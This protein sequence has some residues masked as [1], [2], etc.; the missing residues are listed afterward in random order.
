MVFALDF[1][2]VDSLEGSVVVVMEVVM[3]I[4]LEVLSIWLVGHSLKCAHN[5]CVNGYLTVNTG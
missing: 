4:E 1:V 3:E 5:S 2:L